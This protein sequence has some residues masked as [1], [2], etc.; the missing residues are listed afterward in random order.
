MPS[1]PLL[2]DAIFDPILPVEFSA[3]PQIARY[4]FRE[5]DFN[6]TARV[7]RGRFYERAN[8]QQPSQERVVRRVS[9]DLTDG[10]FEKSLYIYEQYQLPGNVPPPKTVALGASESLWQVV[11]R[12]ERISTGELLFV[13]KA[14]HSFGV[15]PEVDLALIPERGRQKV[16][17]TLSKLTDAAH[18]ESPGSVIDRARDA[19]Q[20][21]LATWAVS[22]LREND[23]FYEDLG[24]LIEKIGKKK[25]MI[26]LRAAE[27]VRRLHSR[28]KP[29]EQERYGLRPPTEDD[30]ELAVKAM[31]FILRELGW[32]AG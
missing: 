25:E 28:V 23:L 30:S 3:G 6:S 24:S 5:D 7:R 29:N 13:L 22:E 15:L 2:T 1:S 27:I 14:R 4:F 18:R 16:V 26:A 10:S 19:V 31:G 9:G 11:A 8:L 21:A 32:S 20:W 12:P 17:E